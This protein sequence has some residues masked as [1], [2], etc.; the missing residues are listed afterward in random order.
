MFVYITILITQLV[1]WNNNSI[2]NVGKK[3][4]KV[5]QFSSDF[6][7]GKM[8][9][10][11]LDF[12][13][14]IRREVSNKRESRCAT[15]I[16]PSKLMFTEGHINLLQQFKDTLPYSTTLLGLYRF[17]CYYRASYVGHMNGQL[18]KGVQ[19][20]NFTWLGR[21]SIKSIQSSVISNI[22]LQWVLRICLSRIA[23]AT[24]IKIMKPRLYVQKLFKLYYTYGPL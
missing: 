20:Y 9:C 5:G 11:M 22:V 14:D 1:K 23:E 12:S 15:N 21:G 8:F 6:L 16:S 3:Q 7:T 10:S 2:R 19:E 4:I 17:N 18:Y 13:E 24:A